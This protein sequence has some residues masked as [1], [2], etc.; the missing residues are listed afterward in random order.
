MTD[1]ISGAIA[2]ASGVEVAHQGETIDT[3]LRRPI[4]DAVERRLL[5]A[6]ALDMSR[7]ALITQSDRVLDAAQ[8]QRIAMLFERRNKGEPIAYLLGRREFHG[9]DFEVSPAVL[10][11]RA[12]T[13]LLVDLAIEKLPRQGS[14]LDMGTGSGAIAVALGAS[15]RDA[16][17]IATD[18]SEAALTVARRNAARHA[19]QVRLL[20]SDWFAALD[21]ETFAMI[22]A[23][24]PYIAAGDTHLAQGDLR[25]EPVDALTDH[26]DGLS[27]LRKII[28]GANDYLD[29]GGWLLLEH[30]Y[31]QA[32]T[33]RALLT[34]AQFC[35]VESWRDLAGIE[36]VSGG[37]KQVHTD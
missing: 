27:A 28:G 22:V 12:D 10:I 15:R 21:G 14:V 9:L 23:N 25:F 2:N 5:V 8:A 31:D 20:R 32:E 3:V 33:V 17:V 13:E 16:H 7:V 6:H 36:R 29:D 1:E 11:P 24:P 19:V 26:Q 34:F 37:R 4:L 35:E 30:G 18:L